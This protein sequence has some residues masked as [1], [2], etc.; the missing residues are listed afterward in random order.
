MPPKMPASEQGVALSSNR[1]HLVPRVLCFVYAGDD[2]LLLKGA[3]NK[4]IWP[5]KYNGLGG[6]VERGET[7]LAAA[8]REIKEEAGLD[9]TDLRLRGVITVDTGEPAGIG[10]FVCTARAP[11][12]DHIASSE[13]TLE[14]VPSARV[15]ELE[16]V[17]DLP[18]LLS[19]LAQLP[20]H[21]PPFSARYWYD[22]E[23]ALQIEFDSSA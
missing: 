12:R 19:R 3:P 6:H 5:G 14:W 8:R 11:G 2:V 20:P 10:L 9:V 23:G 21:A 18:I 16:A 17:T 1:Y 4:R 7:V 13:G 15:A 22:A